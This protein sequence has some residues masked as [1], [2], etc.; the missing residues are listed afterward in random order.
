[1]NE[2]PENPNDS[3][4]QRFFKRNYKKYSISGDSL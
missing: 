2:T 1:M 3:K 4:N